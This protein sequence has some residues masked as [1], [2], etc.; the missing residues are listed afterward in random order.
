[1]DENIKLI[2]QSSR[3][4]DGR[5]FYYTSTSGRGMKRNNTIFVPLTLT[6]SL[7]EREQAEDPSALSL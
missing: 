4:S 5:D 3:R 6:L 2:K 7:M 1:L